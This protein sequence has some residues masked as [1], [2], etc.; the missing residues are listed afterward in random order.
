MSEPLDESYLAWLYSQVA[1]VR[2]SNPSRTYWSLIR[3]LYRTEFIWFVPNDDNRVEDGRD[4][5]V[6]FLESEELEAD[7]NWMD[8]GCSVLEMLIALSR[9]L[10]FEAEG[11]PR[12][13]FW[14][15]MQNL[16]LDQQ[17]DD[18][19]DSEKVEDILNR[20]VY[21][22]YKSDGSGGLFPL[23]G[24]SRDQRKV[25]IWYQLNEYLLEQD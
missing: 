2:L 3:Q 20:L 18:V 7:S 23:R 5:R 25:E 9:R 11:K 6:E 19:H 24:T 10:A 21:R 4:L 15:L 13:W 22:T 16:K 17:T 8:L 12:G 1:S 14:H